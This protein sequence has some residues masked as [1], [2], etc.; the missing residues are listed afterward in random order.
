MW[1]AGIA[2]SGHRRPPL[3]AALQR[4]SFSP[5]EE[6]D[7]FGWGLTGVP[8]PGCGTRQGRGAATGSTCRRVDMFTYPTS[9]ALRRVRSRRGDPGARRVVSSAVTPAPA[10]VA[11]AGGID[12]ATT[13]AV[14]TE[15][16]RVLGPEDTATAVRRWVAGVDPDGALDETAGMRRM[17]PLVVS[18]DGR[19]YR[20]GHLGT[21]IGDDR[22][23]RP[24]GA[25]RCRPPRRDRRGHGERMGDALV[26]LARQALRRR[27]RSGHGHLAH[28]PSGRWRSWVSRAPG[29]P[30][31]CRSER[32]EMRFRGPT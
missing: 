21:V 4:P 14:P 11:A 24:R 17:L 22:A 1:P 15:A 32:P 25:P 26:E 27:P 9:R 10:A 3:R 16:A 12:L 5:Q 18:T 29:H 28:P 6:A 30:S 20:G 19:V 7:R 13:D 8:V 23:R 31:G 2:G